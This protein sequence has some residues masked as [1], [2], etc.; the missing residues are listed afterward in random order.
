MPDSMEVCCSRLNDTGFIVI[1][2]PCHT[3]GP[4]SQDLVMFSKTASQVINNILS[5]C[6]LTSCPLGAFLLHDLNHGTYMS[7]TNESL[8]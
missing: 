8:F 2:S 4:N 7:Q 3:M 5:K 1:I 6:E